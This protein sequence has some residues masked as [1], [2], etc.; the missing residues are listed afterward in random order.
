LTLTSNPA[1]QPRL[2]T[3]RLAEI[4][5]LEQ[6][7]PGFRERLLGLFREAMAQ[8]L[9]TCLDPA[10]VE[11]E[12]RRQSAHALKGAAVGIGAMRLGAL[13]YALE[14]AAGEP[15]NWPAAATFRAE[16]EQTMDLL[17]AWA[18]GVDVSLASR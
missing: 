16:A 2:A 15:G 17:D 8:H 3:A 13:A 5:S 1:E 7:R 6:F 14:L 9:P 18:T 10:S 12:V 4:A 11:L